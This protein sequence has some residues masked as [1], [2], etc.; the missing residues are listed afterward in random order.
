MMV[1]VFRNNSIKYLE[2][3]IY[4]RENFLFCN[5]ILKFL[6]N[7]WYFCCDICLY[8]ISCVLI[9]VIIEFLFGMIFYGF[10]VYFI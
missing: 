3:I 2:N 9:Y 10:S 8:L 1:G 4:L 7:F 6:R 5:I